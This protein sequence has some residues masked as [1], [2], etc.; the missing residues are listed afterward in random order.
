[1]ML[2]EN[3]LAVLLNQVKQSQID[4]CLY[5]TEAM[6]PS[7]YS[8]HSC[9]KRNFPSDLAIELSDVAGEVWQVCFS[10][11]GTKLAACGSREQVILWETQAFSVIRLLSD[12]E[13]G[14]G[15]LA[16]SPDD[17]MIVCCSQDKCARLW[18]VNVS[19][20]ES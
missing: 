15:N 13:N 4:T 1:M 8:D 14:V 12:H 20:L 18:D 16:F 10:H 6:S 9:D 7:L 5:H 19:G 3:R 11:D 17:S 2:P